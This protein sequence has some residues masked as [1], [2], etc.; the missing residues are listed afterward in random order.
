MIA[1][2]LRDASPAK[3][4]SLPHVHNADG[5]TGSDAIVDDVID[6]SAQSAA[7]ITSRGRTENSRHVE[8]GTDHRLRKE[9]PACYSVEGVGPAER[10][11]LFSTAETF[12]ST[13]HLVVKPPLSCS[14]LLHWRRASSSSCFQ[15]AVVVPGGVDDEG[16]QATVARLSLNQPSAG[17]CVSALHWRAVIQHAI[18]AAGPTNIRRT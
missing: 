2:I 4:T 9:D 7:I 13:H 14:G 5:A 6:Y 18:H 16:M 17:R 15:E 10:V 3:T 12:P 8:H 1:D 11:A